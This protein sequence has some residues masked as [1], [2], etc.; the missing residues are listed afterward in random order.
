MTGINAIDGILGTIMSAAAVLII[1]WAV[2]KSIQDAAQGK[3]SSIVQRLLIVGVIAVLLFRPALI[4]SLL[5]A[6]AG[7]VE[8]I[9]SGIGEVFGGGA[10]GGGG[11]GGG[12]NPAPNN[13]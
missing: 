1:I 5:G 12:V 4:P 3:I 10:G 2:F 8:T 13:P 6:L 11:G 7:L 9:I